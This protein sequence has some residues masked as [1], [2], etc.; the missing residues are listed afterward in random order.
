MIKLATRTFVSLIA[1]TSFASSALAEDA[2]VETHVYSTFG[3]AKYAADFKHFDYVN[4]DAPKGGEISIWAPGTFDSFNPYTRK[5][6]SG[7]LASIGF[8]NILVGSKD[9]VSAY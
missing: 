4:P 5:G 9:E 7:R 2:M 8:E 6:R 1:A 3:D